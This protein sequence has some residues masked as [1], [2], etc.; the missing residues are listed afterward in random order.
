MF[1]WRGYVP[2][3]KFTNDCFMCFVNAF[4][5][6]LSLNF[7]ATW[8]YAS[9]NEQDCGLNSKSVMNFYGINSSPP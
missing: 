1:K 9:I 6:S 2:V 4:S 3:T 8:L 7:S 5:L